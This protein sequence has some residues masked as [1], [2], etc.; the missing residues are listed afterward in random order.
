LKQKG[1]EKAMNAQDSTPLRNTPLHTA[2]EK[3]CGEAVAILIQAGADTSLTNAKRETPLHISLCAPHGAAKTVFELVKGGADYYALNGDGLPAWEVSQRKE[4]CSSAPTRKAFMKACEDADHREFAL[5]QKLPVKQR[6][7][8]QGLSNDWTT[9]TQFILYGHQD[10]TTEASV[11]LYP[12]N[13]TEDYF[14]SIG[15]CVI[16]DNE[17]VHELPSFQPEGIGFGGQEALK[18][19]MEPESTYTVCCYCSDKELYGNFGLCVF[20][21]DGRKELNIVPA[22]KWKHTSKVEGAWKGDN[23]AGSSNKFKNTNF[24]VSVETD[25]EVYLML[26][27]KSKDVSAIVFDDNRIVPAKYYI[28]MYIMSDDKKEE[29]A[30]SV[31][32]HNSKE[33]YLKVDLEGDNKSAIVLPTT[34]LPGEELEFELFAFSDTKVYL[35]K[36]KS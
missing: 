15:F 33:V 19:V 7:E 34:V 31:K 18:F 25:A 9:A 1:A 27:Q 22:K 21:K 14:K 10:E 2:G 29:L 12:E 30:K 32:W 23:A 4:H 6:V 17:R 35:K 11:L 3:N 5:Q 26:H 20:Q 16:K 13:R 24:I 36:A 28:G 8:G